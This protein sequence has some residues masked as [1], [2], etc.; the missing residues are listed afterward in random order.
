MIWLAAFAVLALVLGVYVFCTAPSRRSRALSLPRLFAHRGLHGAGVSENSLEAFARACTAGVG[1]ELDVRLSA[2]GSVVV[3]H[4]DTLARL[5]GLPERIDALTLAQLRAFSLPDG[6]GIPTLQEVLDLVAGRVPLLVEIKNGRNL[7]RLCAGTLERL[8]AYKG[9]YAVESFNPLAVRYFRRY[10]ADVPRGQLVSLPDEYRGAVLR[11]GAGAL[12]HLLANVLSRPDFVAYD[13][14]MDGCFSLR[15]QRR[16]YRARL[17]RW[18]V[19]SRSQLQAALMRGESVIF[20]AGLGNDPID[21]ADPL[22]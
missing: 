20:E 19:R 8:R 2:D 21:P 9:E 14:R 11:A 10:A 6:S 4:D 12:S 18:T 7:T 22:A 1:I 17:A 3:F 13:Q 15:M 5:C 16:L